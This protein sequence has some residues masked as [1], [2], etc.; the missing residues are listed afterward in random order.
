MFCWRKSFIISSILSSLWRP[1]LQRDLKTAKGNERVSSKPKFEFWS[2]KRLAEN[3]M[4]K[5]KQTPSPGGTWGKSLH[6]EDSINKMKE[7]LERRAREI[8]QPSCP[9]HSGDVPQICRK[10][11]QKTS[12]TFKDKIL[13]WWKVCNRG[14]TW[15]YLLKGKF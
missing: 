9:N 3:Q 11:T 15:L 10:S 13:R 14:K 6:K 2:G 7:K 8:L 4:D 5:K 12:E 1:Q